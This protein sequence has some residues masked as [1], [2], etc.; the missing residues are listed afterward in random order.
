MRLPD[1]QNENARLREQ[2]RELLKYTI[3]RYH[4]SSQRFQ[5]VACN[6]WSKKGEDHENITHSKKCPWKQ[7]EQA[8]GDDDEQRR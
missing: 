8:L 1:I 2:I 6:A 4:A 5:C 3:P 7:A